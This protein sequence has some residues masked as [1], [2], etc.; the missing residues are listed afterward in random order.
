[1]QAPQ[2]RVH[3]PG[4]IGTQVAFGIDDD[5][6][7][8]VVIAIALDLGL[9]RLLHVLQDLAIGIGF[10][11]RFR[12]HDRI[13]CFADDEFGQFLLVV[14]DDPFFLEAACPALTQ[15]GIETPSATVLSLRA[16]H[17]TANK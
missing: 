17:W 5:L 1:M 3:P 2:L 12:S 8:R 11:I 10:S 16:L 6:M 7:S 15:P 9:G 13:E 4:G 14:S